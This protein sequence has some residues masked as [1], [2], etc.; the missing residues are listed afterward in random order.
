MGH[1][2]WASTNLSDDGAVDGILTTELV[3]SIVARLMMSDMFES[4]A[5]IR[6]LSKFSKRF[7]Y[8]SYHNGS[9]WPHDNSMIAEGF[10]NYGFN[11]EAD[12][13]YKASLDAIGYFKTPIELFVYEDGKYSDYLSDTGQRSCKQQAWSAAAILD[14]VTYK[15][16]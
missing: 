13:V 8:N 9:I 3:P 5:G 4:M 1:V 11:K 7:N 6:T 10:Q 15:N 14:A 16:K 12:D 2:L